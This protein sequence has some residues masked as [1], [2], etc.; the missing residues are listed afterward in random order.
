MGPVSWLAPADPARPPRRANPSHPLIRMHLYPSNRH[1]SVRSIVLLVL[2]AAGLCLVAGAALAQ[3]T[4]PAARPSV[5]TTLEPVTEL[6]PFVVRE[7]SDIGYVGAQSLLGSRLKQELRDI[8]AQIEVFTPEFLLDFDLTRAE[9]A[10]K[11]SANVENS[12]EFMSPSDGGSV[13]WSSQTN[14]RI[15]GLQPSSFSVAREMFSSITT[16]DSY[17]L[18]RIELASGAQSLLFSLGEP[19]GMANMS[20]KRAQMKDAGQVTTRLDTESGYRVSLDFNKLL[21][22]NAAALRLAFVNEN[23]PQFVKPSYDRNSRG[24]G[25]ITLQPF[26]KTTIRVHGELTRET[27]NRPVTHLPF[28]W[29]TPFFLARK[30]GTLATLPTVGF[31]SIQNGATLMW[32]DNAAPIRYVHWRLQERVTS[33]GRLPLDPAKYGAAFDP[34]SGAERITFNP[35]NVRLIPEVAASV[36][37]NF[38]GNNVRNKADSKILDVFVEQ[39]IT[40]TLRVEVAGHQEKW[41]KR[42]EMLADYGNFGY[43]ADVTRYVP[44]VPWVESTQ[45]PDFSRNLPVNSSYALNPNYG[46]VFYHSVARMTWN[47]QDTEEYRATAAWAPETQRVPRWL[48]R[49]SFIASYGTR[50]SST[51]SQADSPLLTTTPARYQN[52]N[53]F[54]PFDARR[55]LLFQQYF[56]PQNATLTAPLPGVTFDQFFNG[57]NYVEPS[58]GENLRF[59][60]W[61]RPSTAR[62]TGAKSE[63]ESTIAAWQGRV[64]GERVILNY[65]LRRDAVKSYRLAQDFPGGIG[66]DPVTGGWYWINERGWDSAPSIAQS[67]NS[68][69]LGAMG[70][71]LPWLSLSYYE[72]STFNLTTGNFSP[73]GVPTPGVSG[74]SKDYAARVDFLGGKFFLKVNVYDVKQVGRTVGGSLPIDAQRM[75]NS[76]FKVIDDRRTQLGGPAYDRVIADEGFGAGVNGTTPNIGAYPMTGDTLSK[77]VEL[78]GGARFGRLDVRLSAAKSNATTGNVAADWENWIRA[79]LPFW[80]KVAD[81]NSLAWDRIPYQGSNPENFSILDPATG[82]RRVMTMKEFYN[83]VLVTDLA[84]AK[85]SNGKPVDT[86]RKYRANVNLA[87]SLTEGRL[88]GV[89]IGSALIYR[90]GPI[91]GFPAKPLAAPGQAF[92]IPILDFQHPYYGSSQFNI[93]A[94]VAYNGKNFLGSRKA[95]RVQVNGSNLLTGENSFRTGKVNALGQSTFTIIETPRAGSATLSFEF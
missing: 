19:A 36:G 33:P 17:N 59:D 76:Y 20:L 68:Y 29:A 28:D 78:T 22:K 67:K 27:S 56:D 80:E 87:Y 23:R 10:F 72:S 63:I 55:R 81:S 90:S 74:D 32:G 31:G 86:E 14:G 58:T 89:R 9:D 65:G 37:K 1:G 35:D 21:Y 70:R 75:E 71:P 5:A 16:A 57:F 40:A 8:S 84:S 6:S 85:A 51:K 15:R 83:N 61:N 34:N 53:A 92:P 41:G 91:V 48:G 4:P 44:I 79:R 54:G 11:Y 18:D 43:F 26:R 38:L 24:Y 30:N 82:I 49:H 46:K 77:G 42:L 7:G 93:D 62:P 95:W 88:R 45:A 13:A 73:F 52:L 39:R 66:Q 69:T 3:V 12:Q 50:T 2:G 64:L 60:G 25:A 94:F 47:L